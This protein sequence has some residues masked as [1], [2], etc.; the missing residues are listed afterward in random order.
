[1]ETRI[2]KNF[3][4]LYRSPYRIVSTSLISTSRSAEMREFNS[5]SSTSLSSFFIIMSK[6]SKTHVHCLQFGIQFNSTAETALFCSRPLATLLVNFCHF[7]K[8]SSSL[9]HKDERLRLLIM[10]LEVCRLICLSSRNVV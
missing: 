7:L 4:F 6:V 5:L 2:N 10:I 1:M 8:V 9:K 3:A